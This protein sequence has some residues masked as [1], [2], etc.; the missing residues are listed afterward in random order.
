MILFFLSFSIHTFTLLNP[1]ATT[2]EYRTKKKI[3]NKSTIQPNE[4]NLEKEP[5]FLST[6]SEQLKLSTNEL[7]LKCTVTGIP[8]PTIQ[9]NINGFPVKNNPRI[10]IETAQLDTQTIVSQLNIS[11]LTVSVSGIRTKQKKS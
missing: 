4:K 9:F 3:I 7:S 8:L 5:K 1:L 2:G 10:N 6:F 11:S